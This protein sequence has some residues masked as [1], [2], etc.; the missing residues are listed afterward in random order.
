MRNS[1]AVE[2]FRPERSENLPATCPR[3]PFGQAER[4]K[5]LRNNP[6]LPSSTGAHERAQAR[7]VGRAFDGNAAMR[8]RALRNECVSPMTTPRRFFTKAD[9]QN[10]SEVVGLTGLAERAAKS[11]HRSGTISLFL[12]A[13]ARWRAAR[14]AER[15]Q[16]VD[17]IIDKG[18]SA[19]E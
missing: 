5:Y 17:R 9:T 14:R 13:L 3:R 12:A 11:L 2:R 18:L 15:L 8:D 10:N 6:H 19:A 1:N 7:G 4:R 16:R